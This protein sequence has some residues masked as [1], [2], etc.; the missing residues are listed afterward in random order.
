[1]DWN[2][3]PPP[4]IA[5]ASWPASLSEAR[6]WWQRLFAAWADPLIE[7]AQLVPHCPQWWAWPPADSNRAQWGFTTAL[8]V[9]AP[10]DALDAHCLWHP[11][12]IAIW[13]A[14]PSAGWTARW[15]LET[16]V[17]RHPRCVRWTWR[18][19]AGW[20]V[21]ADQVAQWVFTHAVR[22][23]FPTPTLAAHPPARRR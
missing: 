3:A 9:P 16:M 19:A 8:D 7:L 6:L 22:G 2:A 12:L 15:R 4:G 23:D 10:L 17:F 5:E 1:M 20:V 21:S 13:L 18:D 11:G 14:E